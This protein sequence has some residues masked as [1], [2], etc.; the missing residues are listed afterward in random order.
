MR[1]AVITAM[2]SLHICRYKN[3]EYET[4]LEKIIWRD[5]TSELSIGSKGAGGYYVVRQ[6][7]SSMT[8]GSFY[9]NEGAEDDFG[10]IVLVRKKS[11]S[12]H[13]IN[14]EKRSYLIVASKNDAIVMARGLCEWHSSHLQLWPNK[15]IPVEQISSVIDSA[16]TSVIDGRLDS[17]ISNGIIVKDAY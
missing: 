16:T 15:S 12:S 9:D 1:G 2:A 3:R 14:D 8:C 10:P 13:W 6:V 5:H 4:T 11:L 7:G 17:G